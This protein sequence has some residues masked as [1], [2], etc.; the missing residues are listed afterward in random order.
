[1]FGK[2]KT[3]LNEPLESDSSSFY[4]LRKSYQIIVKRNEESKLEKEIIDT[5][6][7]QA[8]HDLK[9]DVVSTDIN[10]EF[11]AKTKEFVNSRLL[12]FGNDKYP[13][14]DKYRE[15]YSD[16]IHA[17]TRFNLPKVSLSEN[18][19]GFSSLASIPTIQVVDMASSNK[20]KEIEVDTNA[21]ESNAR[22][23][24]D[25]ALMAGRLKIEA[26][27]QSEYMLDH[28]TKQLFDKLLEVITSVNIKEYIKIVEDHNKSEAEENQKRIVLGV[29]DKSC[30]EC[31][32]AFGKC[33]Q[34]ESAPIACSD[35][36]SIPS[37]GGFEPGTLHI[38]TGTQ[39]ID[40][41]LKNGLSKESL[42]NFDSIKTVPISRESNTMV[43]K[44][45]P[46]GNGTCHGIVPGCE[47]NDDAPKDNREWFAPA[48]FNRGEVK[49]DP[50]C[51]CPDECHDEACPVCIPEGSTIGFDAGDKSI[52]STGGTSKDPIRYGIYPD[53]YKVMGVDP[54]N[55]TDHA[56][57]A[58][59]ELKDG[60]VTI[61]PYTKEMSSE[62]L[63]KRLIDIV[64]QKLKVEETKI[65]ED[66][67]DEPMLDYSTKSGEVRHIA[68]ES[69]VKEV[70]FQES[71]DDDTA[72]EPAHQSIVPTGLVNEPIEEPDE[73]VEEEIVQ[74]GPT[75]IA[76]G[77]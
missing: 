24:R 34:P 35:F 66:I 47:C 62:E 61:T 12:C 40:D 3:W 21:T 57:V 68:W 18:F 53:G 27:Q 1:M 31:D 14:A 11:I 77:V 23:I 70:P 8:E 39:K 16:I 10:E 19:N 76:F 36:K 59:V 32:N 37:D 65:V 63:Q 13:E 15:L 6:T 30:V 28:S 7:A 73:F 20:V 51:I 75:T 22:L 2:F 69:E 44:D 43:G 42:V 72:I 60:T 26:E 41:E 49:S 64:S 74:R 55:G 50:K 54:A 38:I 52:E 46:A 56:A 25:A 45:C 9:K 17:I 67:P 29:E 33:P 58:E 71:E 48:G 4:N 5:F